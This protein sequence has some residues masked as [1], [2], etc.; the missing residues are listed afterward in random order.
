MSA[1][2]SIA[3]RL[4]STL[5]VFKISIMVSIA[6]FIVEVL[7]MIIAP[8]VILLTDILHWSID[9]T[10]EAI[11]ILVVYL[12][13]RAT[14]RFLWSA[15]MIEEMTLV[16]AI[17]IILSIYGFFFIDYLSTVL[18]TGGVSTQS[19]LSALATAIGAV[20]TLAVYII[21][22]R[23]F[24]KY[25]LEILRFERTHSLIDLVSSILA[26]IGIALTVYTKSYVVELLFTFIAM[27]FV[28]H[29]LLEIISDVFNTLAGRNVDYELRAKIR[30]SLIEQFRNIE[31]RDVDARKAGSLYVVSVEVLVD[32]ET[33]VR[34]VHELRNKIIKSVLTLSD[35]VCH[36]DVKFYPKWLRRVRYTRAKK[37]LWFRGSRGKER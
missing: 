6:G 35:L 34:E 33:T 29:S 22:S 4:R 32:P 11:F 2:L 13:S 18:K 9:L 12:A 8:S 37:R 26:T 19:L 36:V 25:R 24:E 23:G 3:S 10:L 5:G 16:F 30:E 20:D 15:V 7:I 21:L 1:G 17:S 14:K 31:I 27:F 28:L